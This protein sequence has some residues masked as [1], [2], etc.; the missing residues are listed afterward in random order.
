MKY[1]YKFR[2]SI[3]SVLLAC[4]HRIGFK[5][6]DLAL[7]FRPG[8]HDLKLKSHQCFIEHTELSLP[9][10]LN[11]AGIVLLNNPYKASR[12]SLPLSSNICLS[13][14]PISQTVQGPKAWTP[15]TLGDH[16]ES[17]QMCSPP[18]KNNLLSVIR[19]T[20]RCHSPRTKYRV[21]ILKTLTEITVA[22]CQ[23]YY[24]K[25]SLGLIKT[26]NHPN[27]KTLPPP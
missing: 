27:Q 16:L 14:V 11:A 20:Q 15:W 10:L 22:K 21:S 18:H 12:E 3:S 13:F 8:S 19:T 1:S 5:I 4:K 25:N 9:C 6:N 7:L 17:P 2:A 24:Y 26:S 23:P